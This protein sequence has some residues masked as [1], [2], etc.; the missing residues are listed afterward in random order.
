MRLDRRQHRVHLPDVAGP[1]RL[2]LGHEL[3]V[4]LLAGARRDRR[5]LDGRGVAA[6]PGGDDLDRGGDEVGQRRDGHLE[7]EHLAATRPTGGLERELD[8]PVGGHDEPGHRRVGDGHRPTGLDL[9]GE[10]L[11]GGTARPEDVAEANAGEGRGV[12]AAVVVGRRHELLGHELA[13]AH[14]GGRIGRLVGGREDH[15][16]DPVREAGIDDVLRP[17]DVRLGRLEGVV[18]AGL[19]VLQRSAMEDD[20]DVLRGAKQPVAIA[21]VADEEPHVRPGPEPLALVELLG[22][23]PAE[24][25]HDG[26]VRFEGLLH[27]PRTDGPGPTGDEHAA[28]LD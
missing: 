7:H 19:D 12:G 20:V 23:V 17:D 15:R 24:D 11:D 6:G 16:R 21:D 4:G 25:A 2:F 10:E 3:L 26:G 9:P 18:L 27:Q 8:G 5:G 14:H 28:A 1:R 22:L 13:R